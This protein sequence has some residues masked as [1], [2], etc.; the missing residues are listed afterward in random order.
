MFQNSKR[1]NFSIPP[2]Q[3]MTQGSEKKCFNT[4]VL[5]NTCI[6]QMNIYYNVI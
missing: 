1:Q 5:Y 4:P 6:D 3:N 2:G